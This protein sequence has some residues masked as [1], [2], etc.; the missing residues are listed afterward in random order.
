MNI[1]SIWSKLIDVK[2]LTSDSVDILCIAESFLNS[3][4]VLDGFEK[5]YRLDVAASSGGLLIYVKASSPSSI[6]NHYDFQKRTQCIAMEL[7]VA[8]KK[9]VMSSIYGPPKQ[10][11]NHFLNNLSEGFDFYSKCC[12]FVILMQSLRTHVWHVF[13]NSKFKNYD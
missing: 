7:N 9:Y 4:I 3:E 5:P 12:D 1:H 6:I 10:N 13:R 8:N 2:I 11:I